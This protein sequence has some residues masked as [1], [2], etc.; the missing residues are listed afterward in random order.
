[1]GV[2][3]EIADWASALP[4]WQ[5]AALDLVMRGISPGQEDYARLL[6][7]LLE[8]AGLADPTTPR[9]PFVFLGQTTQASS[10]PTAPVLSA[11]SNL[12]NVNALIPKQT[13]RFGP[14]LTAVYGGN[15]SGKSGY[16]RVLGCAGF[17]RGDTEILPNVA[18]PQPE[19]PVLSAQIEILENGSP[20]VLDYRIGE[21]CPELSGFYVFDSTSVRVHLCESNTLS[22]SPT[23]LSC[24]TT[25]AE[26][27][28]EV[29]RLL[30]E[31]VDGKCQPHD[32]NRLVAGESEVSGRINALGPDSD[33]AELK[34]LATVSDA[35]RQEVQRLDL[36]IA[37][38]KAR[39]LAKE[40][41]FHKETAADLTQLS[42]RL[43]AAEA[44]LA[45]EAIVIVRDA[46]QAIAAQQEVAE[47]L[48]VQRFTTPSLSQVGSQPWFDFARSARDLAAAESSPEVP[49]P[50]LG[51]VCLLCHQPLSAASRELLTT[52]W[53][54]LEGEAQ[55]ELASLR[56]KLDHRIG[57]VIAAPVDFLTED[58]VAYRHLRKHDPPL[59][60]NVAAYLRVARERRDQISQLP[61]SPDAEIA[62]MPRSP[63]KEVRSLAETE[64]QRVVALEAEQTTKEIDA[65]AQ[66]KRLLEHRIV[67]AE[68]IGEVEH[69]IKDTIWAMQASQIGG[70]TAPITRFYNRL[71]TAL[72]T[73]RYVELFQEI[74]A[75][76][77][78]SLKVK[79]STR[80]RKGEML[81]QIVVQADPSMP[82]GMAKPDKVLSEGEK[83]AVAL[84]DFLTEIAL[85]TASRGIIL[86]DPVTSLDIDWRELIATILAK[87]AAQRQVV[88]FTHD[89]P[90]LY[91]L[92]Q[93]AEQEQVAIATHWIKR[94]DVDDCPGYVFLD[95]SPA[96][97][98][99]Y[100]KATRARDLLLKA[101]T[102]P[103]E[104][105]E[106][107]LSEAFGSLRS[108]YEAFVIFDLFN[109]V[110][111]RF[112][113]RVSFGRLKEVVIEPAI[114]DDI[115]AACERLST[116]MVGH[117]HSDALAAEKP[118]PATLHEEI[119]RFD[120]IRA[121]HKQSAKGP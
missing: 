57:L 78:R 34:L 17:T 7:L 52:L 100:K 117:L 54:F 101:K 59:L 43:V 19:P 23:G 107:L 81:K 73:D 20:R 46:V 106:A 70:S 9:E 12:E 89:L 14:A 27:T 60:E 30:Q 63:A 84:A 115:I 55:A 61:F 118:T 8:D 110:V 93:H 65:L 28:D 16:A 51:S 108:S 109:E 10:L 32:F 35:E 105:Q 88:V 98:R 82:E 67:L 62:P 53:R 58:T 41:A 87:E 22:F 18:T 5:R 86:D 91:F 37:R 111:M 119:Q 24:L 38:L 40:I 56:D 13:L 39:D 2:L 97:E 104:L 36:A 50:Q 80:G 90:F 113:E 42:D 92:K 79:V 72:V 103:P 21:R 76:M 121:R 44:S 69:Y 47:N 75:R 31:T 49:Y 25:L 33:L 99:D 102:A 85:D 64:R 66:A 11:L 120:A 68:H 112:S 94:G 48:S 3:E 1:M 83:R 29:R 15:G 26:I 71:F 96:L 116:L 6:R 114:V 45:D 95:N 4:Y 74:L 77:G